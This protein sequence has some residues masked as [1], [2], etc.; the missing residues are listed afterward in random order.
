MTV[1]VV[2]ILIVAWVLGSAAIC[3]VVCANS[4]RFSRQFEEAEGRQ[5]GVRARLHPSTDRSA[6][7]S[8]ESVVRPVKAKLH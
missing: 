2:V 1:T 4:A 3:L 8:R 7:L 6:S 5:P